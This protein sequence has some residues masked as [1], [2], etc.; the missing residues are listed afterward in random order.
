MNFER[1]TRR[2]WWTT[3]GFVKLCMPPRQ[4][5]GNFI[6]ISNTG[7]QTQRQ[8]PTQIEID[9]LLRLLVSQ[10]EH[11]LHQQHP[12]HQPNRLAWRTV[13]FTIERAK[14]LLIDHRQ[15]VRPVI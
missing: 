2:L 15:T 13:I 10:I 6:C 9:M 8:M 7:I 14:D 12:D 4:S 5:R 11:R 3:P 1:L